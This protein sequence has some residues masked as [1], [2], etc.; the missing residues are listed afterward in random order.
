MY[1]LERFY[2]NII[3]DIDSQ[4]H[5]KTRNTVQQKNKVKIRLY[6]NQVYNDFIV[7]E[8]C[9]NQWLSDETINLVQV[10]LHKEFPLTNG[11]ENTTLGNLKQF[12]V[13]KN[14]FKLFMITIIG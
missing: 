1:A 3:S 13:Q 12:P 7:E 5:L 2:C 14:N 10:L 6:T 4:T 8:L 11:L 9:S